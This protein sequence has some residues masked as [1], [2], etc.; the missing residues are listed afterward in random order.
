MN[1]H[2][3]FPKDFLWGAATAAYQVEGAADEDG[4]GPSIWDGYCR[5]PGQVRNDDNGDI[6]IDHYHRYREDVG[7]MKDLGIKAYRFS[8]SWP[9]VLPTG[10]GQVN[11]KGL[12][13]YDRLIDELLAAGIQPWLTLYHWDL[14]QAL[15]DNCDGWAS[16]DIGRYFADYAAL[17]AQQYSDRVKHYMTLNE[18]LVISDC[19]YGPSPMNPP[20]KIMSAAGRNQVRHHV[21]LAHGMAV[22]ALRANACSPVLIGLAHNAT[23]P[24]PAIPTPENIEAAKRQIRFK[25]G[26]V[27]APILEGKYHDEYLA[28]VGADAPKFTDAEMKIISSPIDFFGF[29]SYLGYYVTADDAA[30]NQVRVLPWPKAYPHMS[31]DWIKICPEAL[32]WLP[33]LYHEVWGVKAVYITEN[34][35]AC[36]DRPTLDGEIIDTDRVMYMR[37]YMMAAHRAVSEGLPLKGYFAWSLFDNFEWRDGY[38]VRFGLHYVNYRTMKRTPKL[39]AKFYREVIANN[40]II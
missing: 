17:M 14:P 10:R 25:E 3:S 23:A 40:A 1:S 8:V 37:Q 20:L 39:S 33:K 27:S 21:I 2:Y 15:E 29:N 12:D 11:R 28:Q 35:C 26:A 9:R 34:G 6:A 32:Y 22:Q 36:D 7:L 4:R 24:I 18:L 30:P 13:F 5:L 31:A 19:G 16:P 38:D